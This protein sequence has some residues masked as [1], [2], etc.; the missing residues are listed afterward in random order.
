MLGFMIR[1]DEAFVAA[2]MEREKRSNALAKQER[3]RKLC[4][5]FGILPLPFA[6]FFILVAGDVVTGTLFVAGSAGAGLAVADAHFTI[7]LLRLSEWVERSIAER[8]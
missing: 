3:V 2:C 4:F 5:F 1:Q 6:L 7:R 8:A